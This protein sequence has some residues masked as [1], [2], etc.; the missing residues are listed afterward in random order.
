M[1]KP[2]TVFGCTARPTAL[3]GQKLVSARYPP[4]RKVE[5]VVVAKIN[6]GPQNPN[7]PNLKPVQ[8]L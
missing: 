7:P 4:V 5:V 1:P 6:G 3:P 8:G 2:M